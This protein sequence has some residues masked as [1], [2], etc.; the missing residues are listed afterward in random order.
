MMAEN[1]RVFT[2]VL[3]HEY[4]HQETLLYMLHAVAEKKKDRPSNPVTLFVSVERR[5]A[6]RKKLRRGEGALNGREFRRD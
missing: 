5:A 3:E 4:M 1:G 6:S 2:M